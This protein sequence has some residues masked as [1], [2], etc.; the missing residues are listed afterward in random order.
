M[1]FDQIMVNLRYLIDEQKAEYVCSIVAKT[2]RFMCHNV[3]TKTCNS[4]SSMIKTLCR[5]GQKH[6]NGLAIEV[7]FLDSNIRSPGQC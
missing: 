2:K 6:M 1:G 7:P 3:P 5:L 4:R